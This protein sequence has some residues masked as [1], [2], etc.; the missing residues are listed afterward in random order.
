MSADRIDH[1]G[2]LTDEQMTR[3]VEHQAALLLRRLGLDKP[4]VG[5]GDS[6]A[7]R[8]GVSRIVLLPF[9]VGLHVGRW[10]QSHGMAKRLEF[11]RPMV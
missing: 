4:H 11:A 7:D 5:P 2:L 8:L 3:A 1:S 9:D 10:H 6:L